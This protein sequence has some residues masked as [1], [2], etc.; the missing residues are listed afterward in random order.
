MKNISLHSIGLGEPL[1]IFDTSFCLLFFGSNVY[2]SLNTKV[3]FGYVKFELRTYYFCAPIL[4]I[5]FKRTSI[6]NLHCK[7]SLAQ[8]ARTQCIGWKTGYKKRDF[9]VCSCKKASCLAYC[10]AKQLCKL[11]SN[12]L[13]I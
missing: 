9:H 1:L 2:Y 12:T 4:K 10:L 5:P 3:S 13:K 6:Y 8:T 7:G 11:V